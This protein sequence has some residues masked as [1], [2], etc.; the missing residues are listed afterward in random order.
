VTLD[1]R[2]GIAQ[3]GQPPTGG[4]FTPAS[5]AQW[6]GLGEG[7]LALAGFLV[8]RYANL[9]LCPA[10]PIG[11]EGRD[12]TR[13]RNCIM[14]HASARPEQAEQ[15]SIEAA[16]S[17]VA[18]QTAQVFRSLELQRANLLRALA[19]A[20]RTRKEC[21]PGSPEH[22]EAK[23]RLTNLQVELNTV[24]NQ[25][26]GAKE[27]RRLDRFLLEIIRQR[28]DEDRWAEFVQEARE[29]RAALEVLK[30]TGDSLA[31][32]GNDG[33]AA[34]QPPPANPTS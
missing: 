9:A 14:Q 1:W 23:A 15:L 22:A 17:T 29:R 6:S 7:A 27:H 24:R 3:G 21:A 32:S 34:V 11:V 16:L 31:F 4:F 13:T 26:R 10:T 28:V 18:K 2:P 5:S 25:T 33:A 20:D 12:L 8:R 30:M 19:V